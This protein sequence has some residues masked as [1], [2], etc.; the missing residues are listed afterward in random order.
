MLSYCINQEDL[1]EGG[2]GSNQSLVNAFFKSSYQD[3]WKTPPKN[4]HFSKNKVE[5]QHYL[6]HLVSP[7]AKCAF[8]FSARNIK[9][10]I[11]VLAVCDHL[12]TFSQFLPNT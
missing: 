6:Q 8:S 4:E 2:A 1:C 9:L 5:K 11:S 7:P 3:F 12:Q 10:N